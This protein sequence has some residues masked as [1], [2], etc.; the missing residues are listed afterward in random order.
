MESEIGIIIVGHC[1]A[2]KDAMIRQA[3]KGRCVLIGADFLQMEAEVRKLN[4]SFE[5]EVKLSK[6]AIEEMKQAL[7]KASSTFNGSK[8]YIDEAKEMFEEMNKVVIHEK[9]QNKFISRPR[10]NFRKR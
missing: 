7:Q 9:P 1:R 8:M 6:D 4:M 5:A 2:G 3:L 10:H